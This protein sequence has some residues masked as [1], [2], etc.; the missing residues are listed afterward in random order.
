MALEP[1]QQYSLWPSPLITWFL[2]GGGVATLT[3]ATLGGRLK[4]RA[5]GV[6]RDI[7]GA[8]TVTDGAGGVFRW[9]LAAGDVAEAGKFDVQFTADFP[10]GQTP[11]L[12][13]VTR[14][15]VLGSLG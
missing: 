4:N 7:A 11:G 1:L 14:L 10:S 12:S 5:T 15:D 9:D 6:E 3:G 2:D 8:L 13:H